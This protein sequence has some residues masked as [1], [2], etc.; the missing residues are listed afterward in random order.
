MLGG[1][2]VV[3]S[4]GTAAR[5]LPASQALGQLVGE[6]LQVTFADEDQIMVFIPVLHGPCGEL[7][8]V[9]VVCTAF[10]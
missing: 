1:F 10:C 5:H 3:W 7:A 4:F 2:T 9:L 8:G 6:I